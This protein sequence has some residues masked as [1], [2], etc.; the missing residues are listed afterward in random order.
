MCLRL[1]TAV[2]AGGSSTI[3]DS[4]SDDDVGPAA[5]LGARWRFARHFASTVEVEYLGVDFDNS[6]PT[7]ASGIRGS[8]YYV[9]A[10]PGGG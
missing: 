8:W 5:A 6:V 4:D 3:S 10:I 9:K 7:K 1:W 2:R